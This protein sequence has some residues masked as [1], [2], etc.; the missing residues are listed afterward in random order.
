MPIKADAT[1][2]VIQKFSQKWGDPLLFIMTGF[3]NKKP[4][5]INDWV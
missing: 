1:I 4:S 3:I 2:T 5:Q